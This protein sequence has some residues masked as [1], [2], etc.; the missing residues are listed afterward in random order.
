MIRRRKRSKMGVRCLSVIDCPGHMKWVRGHTCVIEGRG[1]HVCYG[2]MEAH[3][4]VSR[5][6]GGGDEQV[7]PLCAH[8]H[9]DGHLRGWETFA[10]EFGVDLPA[11]A[12]LF[13]KQSP[14]RLKYEQSHNNPLYRP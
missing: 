13:W 2:R 5:G 8:A 11:I 9:G 6:A 3:H 14:H 1:E 4:V 10:K 12:A 7:V